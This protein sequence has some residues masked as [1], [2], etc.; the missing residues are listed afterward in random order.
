MSDPNHDA[1][2]Y[3][4]GANAH[5]CAELCHI[6]EQAHISTAVCTS[7][8]EFRERFERYKPG[9]AVLLADSSP[10]FA[11]RFL[12]D[13]G[14]LGRLFPFIVAV[15]HADDADAARAVELGAYAVVEIANNGAALI[16]SI[17]AAIAHDIKQRHDL[18]GNAD[19]L[20]KLR[21]LT[22]SEQSVI[23]GVLDGQTSKQ[24][25]KSL[26]VNVKT[27]EAHRAHIMQKLSRED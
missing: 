17:H 27:V 18:K 13:A 25:A 16:E 19:V 11:T 4:I 24:I 12:E 2:V 1:I 3:V 15:K 6:A 20:K 9:C 10:A 5:V 21:T 8:A 22:P 14:G 23:K 7:V 26:G